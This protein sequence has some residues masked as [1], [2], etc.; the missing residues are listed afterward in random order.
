[1]RCLAIPDLTFGEKTILAALAWRDGPGGAHPSLQRI[2][3]DLNIQR[4]RVAH[5]IKKLEAKG[6]LRRTKTQRT[7]S[8]T[9]FYDA[10]AVTKN[11]TVEN[12]GSA[13]TKNVNPAVT[14]FVTQTGSEP[15]SW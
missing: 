3:D 9:I 10:P 14:N 1:M 2:A 4:W 6:R 13:V 7:N 8:Y 5:Y 12:S 11:V 15:E